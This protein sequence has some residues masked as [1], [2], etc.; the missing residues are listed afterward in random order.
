MYYLPKKRDYERKK[1]DYKRKKAI[2]YKN[3]VI[4]LVAL[5]FL[6]EAY[7]ILKA[8]LYDKSVYKYAHGDSGYY[9]MFDLIAC[10]YN[11]EEAIKHG[12]KN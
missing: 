5:L 12:N 2:T 7:S 10:P 3:A 4:I 11:Y 9:S 6:L 8:Y 1:R